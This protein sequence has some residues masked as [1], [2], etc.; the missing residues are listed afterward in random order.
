MSAPFWGKYAGVVTNVDDPY[1]RGR[2]RAKVPDVTGD[3]ESGW[4]LPCFPVAGRGMGWFA[5]PPVGAP[6]WLEFERGDPERPIWC[7]GLWESS[8]D[9]PAPL[10][11]DPTRKVL[12]QTSSGHRILLDDTPGSG[13]ITIEAAGG[14]KIVLDASGIRID[15]GAGRTIELSAS[16]ISMNGGALEVM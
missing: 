11:S 1:R 7:G 14:Q 3:E 9:V 5:V 16:G 15:T 8:A 2:I 10:Q 6:V 13:G 12:L 4:A